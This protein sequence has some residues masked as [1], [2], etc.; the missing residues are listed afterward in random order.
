MKRIL[1][2]FLIVLVVVVAEAQVK[3]YL[4]GSF[5]L[6]EASYIY[7]VDNVDSKISG[8]VI[9]GVSGGYEL[10][11]GAFLLNIGIGFDVSHS[12]VNVGTMS[13][14][15]F[16][17]RDNDWVHSG[18]EVFDYIYNQTSRKD[19]YTNVSLKV[20]VMIGATIKRFY[21]LVGAKL[22]LSLDGNGGVQARISSKPDYPNYPSSHVPNMPNHGFFENQLVKSPEEQ[23][24]SFKPQVMASAEIGYRFVDVV[25]G[26]G[27]DVPKEH[28]YW[29]LG[30]FFDYGLLNMNKGGNAELISLPKYNPNGGS[31]S[32][33]KVNHI[34]S[35]KGCSRVSNMYVGL[36]ATYFFE[37]PK[38]KPCTIC[39][40]AYY[41]RGRAY[42]D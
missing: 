36:R 41:G 21:F 1:S 26:T 11:A 39:R 16:N 6:G 24:Y 34:F 13:D 40:D 22:D 18:G 23:R 12:V 10:R 20:P 27:F 38:K 14:T 28:N 37:L 35:T 15:L 29:R 31:E 5:Q 33:I 4:Y 42:R 25:S 19:S 32:A 30:L 2:L 8:G 9:G 3:N 17:V 7:D